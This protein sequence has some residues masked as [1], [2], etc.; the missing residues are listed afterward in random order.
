ML[1]NQSGIVFKQERRGRRIS[2]QVIFIVN[3]FRR[4][5]W[6]LIYWYLFHI[7]FNLTEDI[8]VL[9]L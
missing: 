5:R 1:E 7:M 6:R 2:G 8:C 4:G 3:I 9:S